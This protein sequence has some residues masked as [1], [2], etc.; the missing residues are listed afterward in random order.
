MIPL[1]LLIGLALLAAAWVGL[2]AT[3]E[4]APPEPPAKHAQPPQTP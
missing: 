2:A 3:Y 1:P 4:P